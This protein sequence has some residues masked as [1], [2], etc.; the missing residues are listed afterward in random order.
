[1]ATKQRRESSELS[2]FWRVWSAI[3]TTATVLILGWM[4]FSEGPLDPKVI[5]GTWLAVFGVATLAG[6]I[7]TRDA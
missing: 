3:T 4:W 1:M 7:S 5:L 2:T 6:W